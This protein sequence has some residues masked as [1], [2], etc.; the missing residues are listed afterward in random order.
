VRALARSL[1]RPC[2]LNQEVGENPPAAFFFSTTVVRSAPILNYCWG[3]ASLLSG[4]VRP[5]GLI[6]LDDARSSN[7]RH[8]FARIEELMADKPGR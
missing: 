3:A 5:V 7:H 4:E 8:G 6:Q 2:D 1:V